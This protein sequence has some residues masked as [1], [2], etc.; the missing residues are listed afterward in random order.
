[1][2]DAKQQIASML[3]GE[4]PQQGWS[5]A[6]IGRY[7]SPS[8]QE[9]APWPVRAVRGGLAALAAPGDAYAGRLPMMDDSGHTSL[10]A[11]G[12]GADLAGLMTLGAG[13]IPAES[14]AVLNAGLRD[15]YAAYL[16]E[17]SG[18]KDPNRI[19]LTPERV[20]AAKELYRTGLGYWPE[21]RPNIPVGSGPS[22][23]RQTMQ[24]QA[25]AEF[26][27]QARR[28]GIDDVRVKFADGPMGSV[29]VRTGDHGTVRFA[30]HA[31][32]EGWFRNPKTG[33]EEYGAVGGFSKELGRRHYPATV[34]VSPASK[35]DRTL[36]ATSAYDFLAAILR[37][38]G[39]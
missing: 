4:Q 1:M 24:A 16:R 30:D 31:Q 34:N 17:A 10:E 9:W 3:A 28:S 18:G 7:F 27:A 2:P 11:I 23:Y 20:D 37:G 22:P 21:G 25:A 39:A 33:Q 35:F 8:N 26:A 32:P 13:A 19:K 14:G 5:L 6:D 12:R 36:D 29:Y 38:D 15:R